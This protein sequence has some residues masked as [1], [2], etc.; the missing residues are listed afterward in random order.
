MK[1][2]LS[3]GAEG[4]AVETPVVPCDRSLDHETEVV[5][6]PGDQVGTIPVFSEEKTGLLPC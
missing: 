6:K 1:P 2:G 3:P 4:R 5:E